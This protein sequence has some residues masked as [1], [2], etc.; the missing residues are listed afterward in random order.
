[1]FSD[2]SF[3]L[4]AGEIREIRGPNGS[5]KSTLLRCIAGL[6]PDF[7]GGI[8]TQPFAYVGHRPGVS[9]LLS[10]LEN[11]RWY[12]DSCAS[13]ANLQDVLARVG[14][15]RY[16]DVACHRLSAGQLRRAALARLLV[17]SRPVWL[18]DEPLTALDTQGMTLI[19]ELIR[20]HSEGGGGVLAATH[21]SMGVE[22]ASLLEL[23]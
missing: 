9:G 5:G 13:A 14:L 4:A 11:L 10:P 7:E 12:A 8:E 18:L 15:T 21:A 17:C 16:A 3:S 19:A 22:N 6:Y 1:M 20:S 2:L 23:G